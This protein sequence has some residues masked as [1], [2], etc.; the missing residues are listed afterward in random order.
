MCYVCTSPFA[1]SQIDEEGTVGIV[2][3]LLPCH[4]ESFLQG[5]EHFP[6]V[7]ESTSSTCCTTACLSR[8]SLPHTRLA[9]S[10]QRIPLSLSKAPR[11]V[12]LVL[13]LQALH[14]VSATCQV[15]QRVRR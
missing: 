9:L 6:E 12:R 15:L 11:Q 8:A 3:G 7:T 1:F 5:L 4:A 14:L 2:R 10:K 13:C